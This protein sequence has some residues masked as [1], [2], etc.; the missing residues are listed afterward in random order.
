M[1]TQDGSIALRYYQAVPD[2]LADD[3]RAVNMFLLKLTICSWQLITTGLT[4]V[5][6]K[7]QVTLEPVDSGMLMPMTHVSFKTATCTI[8]CSLA[9]HLCHKCFASVYMQY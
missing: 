1:R 4:G 6:C 3:S 9:E 5:I 8:K 2:S 7:T